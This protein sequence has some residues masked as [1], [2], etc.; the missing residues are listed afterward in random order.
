MGFEMGYIVPVMGSS[1][2]KE[3]KKLFAYSRK[4][5]LGNSM[6]CWV[7]AYLLGCLA[8]EL[9]HLAR[10]P[11]ELSCASRGT[12]IFDRRPRRPLLRATLEQRRV[13]ASTAGPTLQSGGCRFG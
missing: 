2:A 6:S 10:P 5:L 11:R 4:S 7:C 13:E 12:T 3:E 1:A 8:H 9:G